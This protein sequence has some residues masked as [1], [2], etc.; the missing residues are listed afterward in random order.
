MI[1]YPWIRFLVALWAAF[2]VAT[3]GPALFADMLTLTAPVTC[4]GG[5][6]TVQVDVY[7][8]RPGETDITNTPSC[9]AANGASTEIPVLLAMATIWGGT[10]V[11]IM[12]IMLALPSG[13]FAWLDQNNRRYSSQRSQDWASG[14]GS[15]GGS[16]GGHAAERLRELRETYDSGLITQGEYDQKRKE[17]LKEM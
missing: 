7:H 16:V 10:F 13:A 15:S 6:I 9:I 12:L 14:A 4:P 5:H 2:M 11:P 3:V 1:K 8:P 17:I